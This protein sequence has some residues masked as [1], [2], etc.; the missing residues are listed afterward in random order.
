MSA[1]P[2][3]LRGSRRT[4]DRR[5]GPSYSSQ[6]EIGDRHSA[7][8][9]TVNAFANFAPTRVNSMFAGIPR[10]SAPPPERLRRL[11]DRKGGDGRQLLI[12]FALLMLFVAAMMLRD[13]RPIP[14]R[15]A[16]SAPSIFG[17][18][19]RSVSGLAR[20][21]V[22]TG[23]AEGPSWCRSDPRDRHA[24]YPGDRVCTDRGRRFRHHDGAQC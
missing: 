13:A 16:G 14:V 21:P 9:L 5:R 22:S 15:W 20:F 3:R 11:I 19:V 6:R 17:G 12:L 10:W 7:V 4:R 1:L 8:V 18:S 2:H 24:G 23:S